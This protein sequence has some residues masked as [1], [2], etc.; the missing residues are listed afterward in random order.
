VSHRSFG[1]GL[2]LAFALALGGCGSE[3]E[4]SP[5]AT[6]PEPTAPP[7]AAPTPAAPPAAVDAR[8]E[9]RQIFESRCATCHGPQ[10]AGDGPASA[11]LVPKPRNLRDAA[12]QS[13]VTDSHIEKIVQYGGSAVG[14]SPAMPP[15]PDLGP[16]P[17]VVAALREHVRS[18]AK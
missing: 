10:G 4:A 7:K 18:L 2:A 13:S 11:G 9:A 17:H 12:W 15:N 3:R 14:K 5:G 16:R 6:A 1:V 8:A